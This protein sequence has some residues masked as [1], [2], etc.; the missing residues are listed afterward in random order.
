MAD[1]MRRMHIG[2]VV[3]AFVV[4]L[5]GCAPAAPKPWIFPSVY[6][7][8]SPSPTPV[9]A[10]IAQA[11]LALADAYDAG[12]SG[13]R[14]PTSTA[15]L[16]P[17][18]DYCRRGAQL[19][20][21]FDSGLRSISFT[22]ALAPAAE[23]LALAGDRLLRAYRRCSTAKSTTVLSSLATAVV[24]AESDSMAAA[25]ALRIHLGLPTVTSH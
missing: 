16:T 13:M 7:V 24:E 25:R 11:Y 15:R 1:R 8:R 17:W 22:P 23:T 5:A 18:R 12:I 9:E 3:P 20:Q 4:V 6:G 2:I 19:E 21:R 14:R 10:S